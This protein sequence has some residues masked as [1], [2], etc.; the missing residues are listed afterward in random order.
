MHTIADRGVTDLVQPAIEHGAFL[1]SQDDYGQTPLMRALYN[2]ETL[3]RMC[4][5]IVANPVLVRELYRTDKAGRNILDIVRQQY[6]L[7]TDNLEKH[8]IH[9]QS[10]KIL[11][12]TLKRIEALKK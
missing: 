3:Q 7:H 11:E 5:E 10:L 8:F 6:N 4:D 9:E 2:P 12:N 1:S